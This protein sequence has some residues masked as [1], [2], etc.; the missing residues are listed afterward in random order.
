MVDAD[1]AGGLVKG[2]DG[3]DW[4][5]ACVLL[6]VQATIQTDYRMGW[7]HCSRMQWATA[8]GRSAPAPSRRRHPRPGPAPRPPSRPAG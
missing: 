5:V 3:P 2:T 4:V 6:D 8:A 7:G 1:P